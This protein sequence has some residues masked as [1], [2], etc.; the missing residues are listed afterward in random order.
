LIIWI[1]QHSLWKDLPPGKQILNVFFLSITSRT[2]GFSTVSVG[3]LAIPTL[4]MLI[5]LMYIG[6]APNSTSGGIKLTTMMTLLASIRTFVR[7]K[8]RVEIGWNTIPMRTVRRAFIVFSVSVIL[9][10]FVLF[11]MTWTEK[12]SF[13]DLLFEII[14][15]F[16]T[17][18]LSTG[19]TPELTTTGKLLIT[20]VM[21]A[22]RIG[23]FSFAVAMSEVQDDKSYTFPETNLMVG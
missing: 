1:T 2:A 6:G 12:H 4:M 3:Q 18:G 15:A 22:G 19:I 7:G 23:L 14:S 20:L 21:F 9:I 11:I 8:N 13:I 10:F 16:G 17:V 5:L